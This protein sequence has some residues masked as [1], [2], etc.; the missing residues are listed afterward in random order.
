VAQRCGALE[1]Q[2]AA[3]CRFQPDY[4]PAALDTS[5]TPRQRP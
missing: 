2:Y 5:I 3:A 4:Q 1:A